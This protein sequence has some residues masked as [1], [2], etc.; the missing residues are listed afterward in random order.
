MQVLNV[1]EKCFV[2]RLVIVVF[3][4]VVVRLAKSRF[5][6]FF[7][8][9][10]HARLSCQRGPPDVPQIPWSTIGRRN[11]LLLLLLVVVSLV[12]DV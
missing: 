9:Q 8:E 4:V 7:L 12:V 11:P 3:V 10:V 1:I 5:A 6:F 2:T